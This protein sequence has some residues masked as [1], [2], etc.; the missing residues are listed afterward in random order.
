MYVE[1]VPNRNSPPAFPVRESY[2]DA[3]KVN[4]RTLANLSQWPPQHWSRTGTLAL[5]AVDE[6]ELYAAT[7]WLL[8]RQ[9][10]IERGLARRHLEDG[11]LVLCD[12]TSV[13]LEGR[14]CPLAR[15]GHSRDGRKA[16]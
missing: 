9:Q 16:S 8:T 10:R 15:R 13:Y 6:D 5:G 12:L 1:S 11:A 7:D 4:E 14:S 2:R 3:G